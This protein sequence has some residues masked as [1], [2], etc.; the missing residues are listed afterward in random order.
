MLDGNSLRLWIEI[1]NAT[2]V[3]GG[4]TM[5]ATDQICIR[6]IQDGD[7]GLIQEMHERLSSESVYYRY[8]GANK[9]SF[10]E[11]QHL[12]ASDGKHGSAL[13]AEVNEPVKK[14]VALAFYKIDPKDPSSAE[15]AV[16]VEDAFQGC[17]LGKRIVSVLC[18]RALEKGLNTFDTY[19]HPGNLRVFS[20]IKN[21]GL[22]FECRYFD[23]LRQIRVWLSSMA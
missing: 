12:F 7:V 9:P 13:V 21:S 11:L 1:Q 20:M 5:L 8:L 14:I 15:P 4:V 3:F 2:T 6:E 22:R 18:W 10:A 23:G 16:L 17:G 19:I